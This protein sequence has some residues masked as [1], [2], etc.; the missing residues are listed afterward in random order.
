MKRGRKSHHFQ[1][2]FQGGIKTDRM[3]GCHVLVPKILRPP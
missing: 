1:L 3:F 2:M